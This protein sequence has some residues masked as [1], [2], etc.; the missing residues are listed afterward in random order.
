MN[1]RFGFLFVVMALI[2]FKSRSEK[3]GKLGNV[4][5]N[6]VRLFSLTINLKGLVKTMNRLSSLDYAVSG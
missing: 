5:R 1:C 2:H 3:I 6:T 4:H